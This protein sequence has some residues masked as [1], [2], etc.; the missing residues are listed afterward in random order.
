MLRKPSKQSFANALHFRL[1]GNY[2]KSGNFKFNTTSKK[3]G[4]QAHNVLRGL[5]TSRRCQASWRY[6][7][8]NTGS[9]RGRRQPRPVQK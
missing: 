4:P 3:Y 6:K 9:L 7:G 1:C 5:S 2:S 8:G